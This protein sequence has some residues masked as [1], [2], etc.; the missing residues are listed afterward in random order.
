MAASSP[1]RF[2]PSSPS[3]TYSRPFN[4]SPSAPPGFADHNGRF[5]HRRLQY[6]SR[7]STASTY[8]HTAPSSR[9]ADNSAFF[10][11]SNLTENSRKT[12]LR[13]RFKAQCFRRSTE[14]RKRTVSGRRWPAGGLSSD[15]NEMDLED[16]DEDEEDEDDEAVMRNEASDS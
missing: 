7:I 1:I 14:R 13:D 5:E 8:K 3:S 11:P 9:A 10:E 16:A 15:G 12:F 6:K 4:S 2:S